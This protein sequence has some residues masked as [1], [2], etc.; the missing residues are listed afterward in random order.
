MYKDETDIVTQKH[1]N[2]GRNMVLACI[3]F[4]LCDFAT[5]VCFARMFSKSKNEENN[6]KKEVVVTQDVK[7]DNQ[8]LLQYYRGKKIATTR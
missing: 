6:L 3:V 8:D 1:T 4:G 2:Y 7:K 5:I